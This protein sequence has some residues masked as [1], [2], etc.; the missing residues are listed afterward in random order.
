MP[1]DAPLLSVLSTNK[2]SGRYLRESIDSV[3]RQSFTDYEHILF[4]GAS[5]DGSQEILAS[6][7]HLDWVSEPDEDA[8]HAFD[9]AIARARGK[10]LTFNPISDGYLTRNWFAR[11]VATLEEDP[12][13][14]LVWGADA[15]YTDDGDMLGL[16]FPQFHR[17]LAPDGRA[18]LPYWLATRLWF[19]EQNYVVRADVF[20]SLWPSRETADY[21]NHWNPFLRVILEFN[22]RGYLSRYVK[23]IPSYRRLHYD[24]LTH[25]T[26][27]QGH[28]TLA[29]YVDE[30]EGYAAS[31]L[32][33]R[34]RHVFRD[35]AGE[36]IGEIAPAEL[37]ALAEK[38][39]HWRASHPIHGP[40]NLD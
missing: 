32:S 31:V 33:G 1:P 20:R 16:V 18:F 24:S 11:A 29:M 25:E 14:T 6:Y 30:I 8:N 17:K 10:Y 39:D 15:L 4:D 3:L 2:N 13:V 12:T 7:P 22:K 28:R 19:P 36:P 23:V 27:D 35:G 34:T 21:F 9:K 38:I 26:Q 40:T 5:T 37:P